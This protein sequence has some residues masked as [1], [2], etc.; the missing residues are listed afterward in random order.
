[1]IGLGE[2]AC[3][4]A[5]MTIAASTGWGM[6][7]SQLAAMRTRIATAIA[8]MKAPA[9]LTVPACAFALPIENPRPRAN[10]AGWRMRGSP[11]Q[12]RQFLWVGDRVSP[13]CRQ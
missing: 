1:M 13:D 7:A 9:L 12:V 11:I 2:S 3:I 6:R 8:A 4:N 5:E 10:R